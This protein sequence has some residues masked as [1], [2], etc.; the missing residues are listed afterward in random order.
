MKG[1]ERKERPP[2]RPPLLRRLADQRRVLGQHLAD[3]LALAGDGVAVSPKLRG[4]ILAKAAVAMPRLRRG[5]LGRGRW[6]GHKDDGSPT[7]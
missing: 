5:L 4:T 7:T 2:K 1:R 6:T 3:V